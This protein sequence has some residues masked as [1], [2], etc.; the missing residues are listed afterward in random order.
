MKTSTAPPTPSRHPSA[1]PGP[2][3]SIPLA[4]P[5]D[6]GDRLLDWL[7]R[8]GLLPE[9]ANPNALETS[10]GDF[11]ITICRRPP[12]AGHAP[13]LSPRELEIA[14]MTADGL[15][16]KT[17]AAVLDISTHTVDTHLRRIFAKLGVG[18]RA[19]M[20]TRLAAMK[21]PASPS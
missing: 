15:P 4:A 6:D 18:C 17:I 7:S 16:N 12:N 10:V 14:R 1:K 19:A 3:A 5:A 21:L 13:V 20:A 11:V 8:H 2:H 9:R